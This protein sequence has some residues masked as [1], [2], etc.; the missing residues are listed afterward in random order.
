[1]SAEQIGDGAIGSCCPEIDIFQ[2]NSISTNFGAHPCSIITPSTC[3]GIACGGSNSTIGHCDYNGCNFNPYQLGDATFY[4]PGLTVNTNEVFTVVTQ[5][6]TT[7]GF[8]NGSLTEIS[9]FYIQNGVT[10]PN[11]NF[12]ETGSA[13]TMAFCADEAALFKELNTFQD[14]GSFASLTLALDAGV[15]L[16]F[17]LEGNYL[18]PNLQWLDGIWP[19]ANSLA[20]GAKRGTCPVN[21][22]SP[23]DLV[24]S[25]DQYEGVTFSNIRVGPVGSTT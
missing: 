4:G 13:I 10:I 17:E 15:V 12:L 21:T 5:F 2:S 25:V 20:A 9:R 14:F 1:L 16:A 7:N 6:H 19:T 22:V 11:P 8:S 3:S 23:P 18:G 24:E